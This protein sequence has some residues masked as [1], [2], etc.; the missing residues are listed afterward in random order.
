MLRQH[1]DE[2]LAIDLDE[3]VGLDAS[4]RTRVLL[5]NLINNFDGYL[6]VQIA[7]F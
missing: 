3:H 7:Q 6:Q 5:N 1:Q 4:H 2:I